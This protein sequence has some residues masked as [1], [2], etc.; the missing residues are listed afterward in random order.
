MFSEYYKDIGLY[1]HIR[2]ASRARFRK[3]DFDTAALILVKSG[4]KLLHLGE[5]AYTAN[6]NDAIFVD[7]KNIVDVSN[8]SDETGPYEAEIIVFDA[9]LISRFKKTHTPFQPLKSHD[10]VLAFTPTKEMKHGLSQLRDALLDP[11]ILPRSVMEHKMIEVLLWLQE[12]GFSFGTSETRNIVYEVRSLIAVECQKNWKTSD[13][14][15][16]LGYSE[17][18]LRR[19][20]KDLGTSFTDIISDVRMMQALALLQG[21]D[22]S[23]TEISYSV[24]YQSPSKF[25]LRFKR[26][27]DL[28]PSEIRQKENDQIGTE[29]DLRGRE[30]VS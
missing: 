10:R 22:Q 13:I 25:A 3:I 16:I 23:I 20:L 24:G 18:T 30:K 8:I 12:M 7:A 11:E 19:R 4:R 9:K 14:A 1:S 6:V 21:T 26:R 15:N 28:S 27:F 2:Q 17:P 5:T 29:I